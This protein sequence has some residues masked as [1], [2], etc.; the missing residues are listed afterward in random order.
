MFFICI[1]KLV[2]EMKRIFLFISILVV[3]LLVGCHK[4]ETLQQLPLFEEPTLIEVYLQDSVNLPGLYKVSPLINLKILINY[5][6]GF[7]TGFDDQDVDYNIKLYDGLSLSFI[8]VEKS[9][10]NKININ[11]AT[12]QQLMTLPNIGE[13]TANNI[14]SYRE[15]NG[16]FSN[17]EQLLNVSGIGQ[18]KF[19]E[20]K[21][22]ITV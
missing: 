15:T 8:T 14:I 3:I 13:V 18:I 17:I 16:Y 11:K 19:D 22:L 21:E 1:Y 2:K 5:A 7:I 6:G 4:E 20:I 9:T 10:T 12:K